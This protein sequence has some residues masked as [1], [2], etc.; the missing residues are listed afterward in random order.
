MSEDPAVDKPID[1]SSKK[2]TTQ[3][4]HSSLGEAAGFSVSIGAVYLAHYLMPSQTRA[5][6]ETLAERIAKWRGTHAGEERDLAKKV[7]DVTL[8]NVGGLSN[9]AMQ[10]SLHR[11]S[12][13]PEDKPPLAHEL[14]RF[15]FRP[16]SRHGYRTKHACICTHPSTQRDGQRRIAP[17][18]ITRQYPDE[19][20]FF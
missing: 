9:M 1:S 7:V 6:T 8:M 18:K 2:L 15:N 4:L 17:F 3:L 5:V 10:F 20:A 12:M 19:C 16:R 14:G 11:A 13:E